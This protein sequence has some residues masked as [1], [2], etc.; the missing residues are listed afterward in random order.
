MLVPILVV[1]VWGEYET[2][3]A[4]ETLDKQ[5]CRGGGGPDEQIPERRRSRVR[6]EE[7][8]TSRRRLSKGKPAIWGPGSPPLPSPQAPPPRAPGR[9]ICPPGPV[10]VAPCAAAQPGPGQTAFPLLSDSVPQP[11][12]SPRLRGRE[13]GGTRRRRARRLLTLPGNHVG[14]AGQRRPTVRSLKGAGTFYRRRLGET[15]AL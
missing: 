14:A 7:Q 3:T 6:Q 12:A 4:R 11:F 1:I 8:A 2:A 10:L 5:T 9:P 13:G 15:E